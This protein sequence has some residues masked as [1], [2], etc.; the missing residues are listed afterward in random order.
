MGWPQSF[1][2]LITAAQTEQAGRFLFSPLLMYE[3]GHQSS[4]VDRSWIKLQC[5]YT[6]V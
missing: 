2:C 1:K 6:S 4:D 3:D 5:M